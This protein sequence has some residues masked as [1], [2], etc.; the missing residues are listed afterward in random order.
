MAII[1]LGHNGIGLGH[2]SRIIAVCDMIAKAGGKPL[3]VSE[4]LGHLAIPHRIPSTSIS[5]LSSLSREKRSE[6][7]RCINALAV[8]SEPAVVIEDTHPLGLD[9]AKEVT[10]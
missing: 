5:H 3:L 1:A 7:Q 10:R 8:M 6:L 9:L 2:I 4:G